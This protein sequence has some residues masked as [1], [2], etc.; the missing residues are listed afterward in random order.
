MGLGLLW[1]ASNT[2]T[3][4][5]A[6]A[7]DGDDPPPQEFQTSNGSLQDEDAPKRL[8]PSPA[9]Y[10]SKLLRSPAMFQKNKRIRVSKTPLQQHCERKEARTRTPTFVEPTSHNVYNSNTLHKSQESRAGCH[11]LPN[12]ASPKAAP[13]RSPM[14][15]AISL[16]SASPFRSPLIL[17]KRRQLQKS[18]KN[19]PRQEVGTYSAL[20]DCP[21]M[22]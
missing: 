14:N 1:P 11:K 12:A 20:P 17:K 2:A 19:S 18:S 8:R 7:S 5:V 22:G 9:K 13:R 15:L 10:I 16:F 21:A 6:Q 4:T 3:P